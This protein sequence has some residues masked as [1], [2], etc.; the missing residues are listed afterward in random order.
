MYRRG[1]HSLASW[2]RT[3]GESP[4]NA[5][6]RRASGAARGRGERSLFY[7]V[8]V[9]GEYFATT[10]PRAARTASA[11]HQTLTTKWSGAWRGARG[12][13]TRAAVRRTRRGDG[14]RVETRQCRLSVSPLSP[15]DENNIIDPQPRAHYTITNTLSGCVCVSPMDTKWRG[16]IQAGPLC[17]VPSQYQSSDRAVSGTATGTNKSKESKWGGSR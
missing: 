13:Y 6:C 3:T 12:A 11:S 10:G 15:G 16:L 2:S 17:I 1:V 7:F 5:R 8:D 4:D 9:R 14:T